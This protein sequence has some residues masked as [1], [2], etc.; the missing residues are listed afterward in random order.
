[1]KYK[2]LFYFLSVFALLLI[3]LRLMLPYMLLRMVNREID[4]MDG[5][6]GY[7]RDIDVSL[8]KGAYTIKTI[9]LDKTTAPIPVPFFA[10]DA[11]EL[12][13]E[14]EPLFKGQLVGEIIVDHAEMNFVNGPTKATSQTSV[15]KNWIDVV[16]DLMPLRLNRFEVLDG[17]ISYHD[18]HSHPQVHMFLTNVYILAK[19]L[20][21][22][23]KLAKE[24]PSTV[25]ATG[26]AYGGHI[27]FNMDIDPLQKKPRFDA[28]AEL[29]EMQL[30]GINDFLKAYG[31]FD[32]SKGTFSV[33]TEAAANKGKITGYTKPILKEV[34]VF[35]WKK[36]EEKGKPLQPIWEAMVGAMG[37]LFKNK[38][39]DQVATKAE[40]TGDISSPEVDVWGIIGQI[41]RNAFIQALFPSLENSVSLSS[42]SKPPEKKKGFFKQLFEKKKD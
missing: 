12:S 39:K 13:I 4:R 11:I 17:K 7:V 6:D 5:Y 25:H 31:H 3:V 21:N 32:V 20:S 9:R 27:H 22:A 23:Q 40:F 33:Y 1:M 18:F 34:D 15:D 2:K 16:D 19:N 42:L 10:A 37:W 24:L 36:D 28:K 14:W 38:S 29:T 35:D 30:N 26:N 41:L 8:I